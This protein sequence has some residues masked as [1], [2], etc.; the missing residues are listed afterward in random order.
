M[1]DIIGSLSAALSIASRLKTIS[2]RVR[3]AEF[4]NLLADLNIELAEAKMKMVDLVE[5]NA[6]LKQRIQQL[7]KV[8]GERCPSCHKMS[9][10][11]EHSEPDATLGV[12]GVNRRT[13]RCSACG[14][15]E[16]NIRG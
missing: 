5:E 3:D 7:E 2:D 11:L 6:R 12:V 4:R 9:W 15:T 16:A 1:A 14:F 8:E 10:L 13:Y